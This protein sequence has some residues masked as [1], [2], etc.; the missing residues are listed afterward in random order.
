MQASI[1][2]AV[3]MMAGQVAPPPATPLWPAG[4]ANVQGTDDKDVPSIL[5]YPAAADRANG[6]AVVI[7]P[8][9][10]YGNL[11]MDHEGHQAARWL[12]ELGVTAAVLKYRLGPKYRHPTQLG[13]AQRA[14]RT[15]RARAGEWKIDPVKIGVLGFS[16]GGHLA[17]TAATHFDDGKKDA[18]DPIDRVSSRPDFLVAVYPVVT[19]SGPNAHGGSRNNLLGKDADAKLIEDLSNQTRVTPR[20]PPTFLAHT[21]D[22]TA[23]PPENSIMFYLACRSNKVPAELHV[24]EKG[25][26]GLGLAKGLAFGDWPRRCEVWLRGRAILPAE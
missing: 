23:V 13:D 14:I 3:L 4:A 24:Y 20:T 11:A 2:G 17:T 12:N 21:T 8:G 19:L 26:H 22:D 6:A 10:G 7:C 5:L 18:A 16:A 9:G 15:L 25:R 1:L